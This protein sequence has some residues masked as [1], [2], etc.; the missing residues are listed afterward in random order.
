MTKMYVQQK[1]CDDIT[2]VTSLCDG[3]LSG[4]FK[5]LSEGAEFMGFSV[6]FFLNGPMHVLDSR[7]PVS[8]KFFLQVQKSWG[9]P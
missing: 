3:D 8:C 6:I 9:F 7:C 4:A 1:L 5:M 2:C